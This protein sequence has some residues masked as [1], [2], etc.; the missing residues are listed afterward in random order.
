MVIHEKT[1][2][3]NLCFLDTNF[4]VRHEMAF[5]VTQKE[6]FLIKTNRKK[7]ISSVSRDFEKSF[8]CKRWVTFYKRA[9][10]T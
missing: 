8:S 1:R 5:S 2:N 3:R 4:L 9:T 6:R 7:V 10:G